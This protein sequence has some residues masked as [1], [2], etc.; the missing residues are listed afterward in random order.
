MRLVIPRNQARAPDIYVLVAA[1]VGKPV[2]ARSNGGLRCVLGENENRGLPV[3]HID[4]RQL[5]CT[6]LRQDDTLAIR[7]PGETLRARILIRRQLPHSRPAEPH[8]KD[9]GKTIPL[10][11][12]RYA[13][14][15]GRE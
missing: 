2:S 3:L 12:E 15:A 10:A 11:E 4:F 7:R 13:R 1:R 8:E 9:G 14:G 5:I 6:I